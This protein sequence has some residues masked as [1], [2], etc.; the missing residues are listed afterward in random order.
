MANKFCVMCGRALGENN[1]FC[2]DCGAPVEGSE[3]VNVTEEG[4][5]VVAEPT[6]MQPIQQPMSMS[7]PI[8]PTE[9]IPAKDSKY[10]PIS[11]WGYVGIFLL[12][13]IPCV[14]FIVLCVWAFGGCRKVNQRNL[15]RAALIMTVISLV[16]SMLMGMYIKKTVTEAVENSVLGVFF[17]DEEDAQAADGE[18]S[19]EQQ[20][21]E[22]LLSILNLLLSQEDL[23][24]DEGS[25][26][27]NLEGM[28]EL[29]GVK[30]MEDLLTGES[31]DGLLAEDGVEGL[32]KADS[33]DELLGTEG[34]DELLG[35]EGVDELMGSDDMQ[36]LMVMMAVLEGLTSED[37]EMNLSGL[38]SMDMS[39][40]SN[41]QQLVDSW[42]A[43]LRPYP[44]GNKQ[45]ATENSTVYSGTT[46]EEV[47]AYIEELKADGF[48]YQDISGSGKT[49]DA[50]LSENT[51]QG[52]NGS[53][54][55]S[56]SYAGGKV[57]IT[58][59]TL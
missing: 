47:K 59:T 32:M 7:Q 37:S 46:M 25:S 13:G 55:I 9:Y 54:N 33:V 36:E 8:Q 17:Q 5:T 50:M 11:V 41:E 6:Q 19:Q 51:W 18:K 12:M 52:T 16:F 31:T 58:Y 1:R 42:P 44:N 10:Q 21:M 34:M 3:T 35:E 40:G 38:F 30:G 48:A 2:P 29:L 39:S 28:D 27:L 23:T 22:A 24:S 15:S 53:L 4:A 45:V 14:G 57:T 26:E 20:E 49:E 56:L 43:D